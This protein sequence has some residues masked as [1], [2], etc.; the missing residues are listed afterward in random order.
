MENSNFKTFPFTTCSYAITWSILEFRW[1][2]HDGTT[3][4]H[5]EHDSETS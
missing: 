1:L 3:R 4:S 5:S 2:E